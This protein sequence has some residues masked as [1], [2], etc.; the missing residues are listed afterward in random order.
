MSETVNE[1]VLDYTD[2]THTKYPRQESKLRVIRDPNANEVSLINQYNS[3][4]AM[5]QV[6]T[7]TELLAKNP[8]LKECIIN[9][10]ILL[11]LHHDI[12]AVQRY[13][14]DFVLDKIFRIGNQKGDWNVQMSCDATDDSL[15]LNKYDVVRYPVDG[16][17]QYFL[18]IGNDIKAGDIPTE[19]DGYIQLTIKGD[20]GD[21][22]DTGYSPVK[23]VD[24]FDGIDGT[25]GVDGIG[26][27]PKGAWANN[28]D[29]FQ[30]DLVSHN[31]YLWYCLEDNIAQE[32]NDDSA[33]WVKFNISMQS[34][35][36]TDIPTNLENGGIWMHLQDDGHIILKTKNENGEYVPMYPETQASYVKDANGKSVQRWIY[37]HYFEREDVKIEFEDT[38]PV[39]TLTAR[40][41]S[42]EN[43]IVAKH[44]ITD[45][46]STNKQKVHEFTAY[47]ETG[48]YVMYRT[49]I[50]DTWENNYKVSSV[51]EVIM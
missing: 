9:A 15:R 48:I 50:V 42:N 35:V 22:G 25:D 44:T 21:K 34:A 46:V 40:L 14:Y 29:Y 16:L 32:P 6:A 10:D 8:S 17:N 5:G 49:K 24:Y 51:T 41:L 30:Y 33:I 28:R 37:Q 19:T 27:N 43:I 38:D 36:G 11:S 7:A 26:M 4:M 20:K 31:G 12:I 47:D 39:F 3:Y 18:V 2:L 13:F 45:S 23:G 1:V